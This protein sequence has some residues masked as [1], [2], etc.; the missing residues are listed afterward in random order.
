MYGTGLPAPLNPPELVRISEHTYNAII[1]ID[2]EIDLFALSS[3]VFRIE[4]DTEQHYYHWM[5]NVTFD[6]LSV[7]VMEYLLDL[8]AYVGQ[9]LTIT[10]AIATEMGISE[11]SPDVVVEMPGRLKPYYKEWSLC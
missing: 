9:K 2:S 5:I 1:P 3:P 7:S 11:Y 4:T 8:S 10:Y 6:D